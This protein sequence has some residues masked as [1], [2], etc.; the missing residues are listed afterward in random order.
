MRTLIAFAI[1]M[2]VGCFFGVMMLAI[3]IAG[4]DD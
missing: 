4:R 2:V 3:L 1:G